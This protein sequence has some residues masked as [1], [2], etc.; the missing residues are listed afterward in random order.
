VRE[1]PPPPT[2]TGTGIDYPRLRAR[3]VPGVLGQITAR[4]EAHTFRH[5]RTY[6][7]A[8]GQRQISRQT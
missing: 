2:G 5:A 1:L 3:P 8:D 7:L 4:T 6:A